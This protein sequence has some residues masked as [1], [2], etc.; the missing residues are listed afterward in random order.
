MGMTMITVIV[1][2]GGAASDDGEQRAGCNG[3]EYFHSF[4]FRL[5]CLP[6]I[7]AFKRI[8]SAPCVAQT[9]K[10]HQAYEECAHG[11][12]FVPGEEFDD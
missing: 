4:L 12:L 8:R 2:G 5:R 7:W 9:Y 10:A 3:R 6:L 1:V 11:R